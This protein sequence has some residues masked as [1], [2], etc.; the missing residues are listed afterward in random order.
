[1]IARRPLLLA[2]TLAAGLVVTGCGGNTHSPSGTAHADAV[3]LL[4]TSADVNGLITPTARP[5]RDDQ[6]LNPTTLDPSFGSDTPR[7][8]TLLRGAAEFDAVGHSGISLYAHVF[9]FDSLAGAQSLAQ[10]FLASDRLSGSAGLPGNAPGEQRQASTQTY[11]AGNVS[12]RYSFREQ[13][14]LSY[15]ELDGPKGKFSVSDAA[16]VAT[17]IDRRIRAALS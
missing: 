13:N 10:T 8:M 12:Y 11:G 17:A 7:A 2:G 3:T 9:V 16:R 6:A 4:P 5:N 1:M 14:V 15:I